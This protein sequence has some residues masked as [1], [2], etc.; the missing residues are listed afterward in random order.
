MQELKDMTTAES[1]GGTTRKPATTFEEL[2]NTI[3]DSLSDLAPSD[4]QQ[5]GEDKEDEEEDTELGKLSDDEPG[6]VMGTISKNVQHRM[7]SFLQKQMRL[8][9]L[10]Q[11]GW[12][13]TANYFGERDVKYRTAELKVPVVVNHQ[14]D[15]IA[16]T[17]SPISFGEPMPT[18]EIVSGQ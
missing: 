2:M 8:E 15:P 12:G 7:E 9:K 10:A 1:A 13:D 14:I 17:P 16:A 4:N 18:L 11:P 5:D 3:G 6:W